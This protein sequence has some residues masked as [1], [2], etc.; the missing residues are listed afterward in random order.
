MSLLF[1]E[2]QFEF[3]QQ[4]W[5]PEQSKWCS[6][7]L[8]I[9]KMAVISRLTMLRQRRTYTAFAHV[10]LTDTSVFPLAQLLQTLLL[11]C[12]SAK[13]KKQSC[14]KG[15][16]YIVTAISPPSKLKVT[17]RKSLHCFFSLSCLLMC[18]SSF[19]DA[20]PLC[21]PALFTDHIAAPVKLAVASFT[22]CLLQDVVASPA[23]ETLTVIH[24]RTG[25]VAD[26]ALRA[27]RVRSQVPFTEIGRLFK[28]H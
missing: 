3:I 23:A 24:T 12:C 16:G 9:K 15:K 11:L 26:P 20:D 13:I 17:I 27:R 6:K 10:L 5:E 7:F 1:S 4:L 21:Y 14:K 22:P 28:V 2:P 18:V 8:G 19:T 25:L